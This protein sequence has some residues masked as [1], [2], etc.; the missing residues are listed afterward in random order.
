[1]DISLG[2]CHY[3]A[4]DAATM[5]GVR[6]GRT[7]WVAVC[8]AH[9]EAAEQDGYVLHEALDAPSPA[10]VAAPPSPGRAPDPAPPPAGAQP[11]PPGAPVSD[12]ARDT[13]PDEVSPPAAPVDTTTAISLGSCH[14]G[15]G[16]AATMTGVHP[17]RTGWVAVCPAHRE[18]AEQDGYELH[19]VPGVA[20]RTAAPRWDPDPYPAAGTGAASDPRSAPPEAPPS[21]PP[22]APAEELVPAISIGSC[23]YGGGD[24]ATMTG[25]RPGRTG[26]VPVCDAHRSQ[27][28]HDGYELRKVPTVP[29]TARRP[30]AAHPGGSDARSGGGHPAA[31]GMSDMDVLDAILDSSS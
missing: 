29:V 17:G 27:A 30:A 13:A 21:P 3:G 12:P 26:W 22:A 19:D 5:T 11:A 14:Y 6:P 25:V 31:D 28:E 24:V 8:P 10:P 7:G 18:A 4:G 15:A 20:P 23:H 2:S 9:R 16:D 1:M